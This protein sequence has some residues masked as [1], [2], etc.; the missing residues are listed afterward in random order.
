MIS[1]LLITTRNIRVAFFITLIM[2]FLMAGVAGAQSKPFQDDNGDGINDLDQNT[3]SGDP[4]VRAK[5]YGVT[6]PIAELGNCQS[7]Y[8]CRNYCEDPVNSSACLNFGKKKG[9]YKD[10]QELPKK[11]ILEKAKKELG[12][13]SNETCRSFCQVQTNY[14]KCNAFAKREGLSGGH[15]DDP[16]NKVVLEKAKEILGCDS[17]STCAS[18]C[19]DG[20]NRGKCTQFAKETGLKGGEQK[21]GPGGCTSETTCKAFCSDPNNFQ[22]CKGFVGSGGGQFIGPGGCNSEES[23]RDYC[24][25]NP[26]SCRNIAARGGSGEDYKRFCREQPDKCREKGGEEKK[27]FEKYCLREPEKCRE[28]EQ[29]RRERGYDPGEMCLRTPAC[30]WEGNICQCGFYGGPGGDDRS[31]GEEYAR[32]CRENPDRCRMPQPGGSD[33][34]SR[35]IEPS[36][37]REEQERGCREG[38]G[39]CDWRSGGN[40][41]PRPEASYYPGASY[42]PRSS[43]Q[44]DASYYPNPT[45]YPNQ[46]YQPQASYQPVYSPQPRQ[47]SAPSGISR[48]SQEAGCRSCGGTCDWSGDSCNCQCAVSASSGSTTTQTQPAPQPVQ[49]T[50]TTQQSEPAPTPQQPSEP[51]PT[52]A[53]AVQGISKHRTLFEQLSGFLNF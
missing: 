37:S 41:F 6:F 11:E 18:Y 42:Y 8:D 43:Y 49:Q 46:S 45:Y 44:P 12:C 40:Y 26:D 30:R 52:Q 16:K 7:Y 24:R 9:F 25:S 17:Y 53:P 31:R 32:F 5:I 20:A 29:E 22:V 1:K 51:V 2:L 21:V 33:D 35:R 48:E 28:V 13:D 15:V 10:E 47:T 14:E 39:T 23:C 3:E 38:G 4:E 34:P 27:E 50:T 36:G 19:S